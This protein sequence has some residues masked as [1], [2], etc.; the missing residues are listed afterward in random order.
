MLPSLCSNFV[1][2]KTIHYTHMTTTTYNIQLSWYG[3]HMEPPKSTYSK[4]EV[5]TQSMQCDPSSRCEWYHYIHRDQ[6]LNK[7]IIFIF[8]YF[9]LL[10]R[11]MEL[12]KLW[13]IKDS[14]SLTS[15]EAIARLVAA[16]CRP[17]S[18]HQTRLM[19]F[20]AGWLT[21]FHDS[22]KGQLLWHSQ[23]Q[24]GF[25]ILHYTLSVLPCNIS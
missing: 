20:L 9:P 10:F 22:Y 18:R 25:Q 5:A 17:A 15:T 16:V 19:I 4:K 1:K 3:N 2:N 12:Q 11:S 8:F 13:L 6:K 14:L 21:S 7:S 24:S 23:S